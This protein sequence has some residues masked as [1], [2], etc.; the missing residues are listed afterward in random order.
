MPL[1][2]PHSNAH[3]LAT[4]LACV[5]VIAAVPASLAAITSPEPPLSSQQRFT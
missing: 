1:A 4:L 3:R 2:R 5:F